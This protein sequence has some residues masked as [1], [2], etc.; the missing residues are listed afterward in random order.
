[1]NRAVV[2]L[3]L[4]VVPVSGSFRPRA[5]RDIPVPRGYS[6]I[7]QKPDSFSDW[8]TRLPLKKNRRILSWRGNI[9]KR[10][11]YR[12]RAV[13]RMPLLFRQDLEQCADYCMRLWAEYHRNRGN[14]NGLYLYSYNGK[15][16]LFSGSGQSWKVFLKRRM[17]YSNSW[18]LKRG[19]T[20]VADND[21]RPGDMFIQNDTGRIGHAT[22]VLDVC[23]NRQGKR[24]YLIGYGFMPAQEFHIEHA[25]PRYGPQ[26]WLTMQGIRRYLMDYFSQYG[27]PVIRRFAGHP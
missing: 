27:E 12:V 9:I 23:R 13:L 7:A 20:P 3:L 26:G 16:I 21:I 15:K 1:M 11:C 17:Q 6:R 4:A 5:I 22:M 14:L 10:D 24:F 19:G 2:L 18:S 25:R 8:I